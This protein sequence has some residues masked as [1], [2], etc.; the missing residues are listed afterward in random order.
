MG[1]K[2]NISDGG[3]WYIREDG[4]ISGNDVS[5]NTLFVI[6]DISASQWYIREDGDISGNDA[7][8]N[9]LFVSKDISASQWYIR[10]NGD[11]SG[12]DASFNKLVIT[13]NIVPATNNVTIGS[14]DNP[15]KDLYVSENSLHFITANKTDFSIS[16]DNNN[17]SLKFKSKDANELVNEF[18]DNYVTNNM[19]KNVDIECGDIELFGDLSAN[20]AHFENIEIS[21]NIAVNNENGIISIKNDNGNSSF[22]VEAGNNLTSIE[23]PVGYSLKSGTDNHWF[24]GSDNKQRKHY[25]FLILPVIVIL[26]K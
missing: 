24:I 19:D 3:N 26:I 8:F 20:N 4:D 17:G 12:N 1:G 15:I 2:I 21:G 18:T 23:H 22:I 14:L 16:I 11:I 6:K 10:E 13:D 25:F 5:F 9:S 7:S